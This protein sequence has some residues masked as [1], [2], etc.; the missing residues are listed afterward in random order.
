MVDDSWKNIDCILIIM[1]KRLFCLRTNVTQSIEV[2]VIQIR[3]FFQV[4]ELLNRTLVVEVVV[5]QSVNITR[6]VQVVETQIEWL[7]QFVSR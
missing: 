7:F 1:L 4:Y 3:V 2:V 5:E 6:L